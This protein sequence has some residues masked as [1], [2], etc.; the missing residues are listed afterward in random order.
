MAVNI[1]TSSDLHKLGEF[2]L[3]HI[4]SFMDPRTQGLY[5]GTSKYDLKMVVIARQQLFTALFGTTRTCEFLNPHVCEC[6]PF[7]SGKEIACYL[8]LSEKLKM[9]TQNVAIACRRLSKIDSCGSLFSSYETV[10]NPGRF[11]L[12]SGVVRS[13]N[14]FR[15]LEKTGC[16]RNMY[17][18][19]CASDDLSTKMKQ[20]RERLDRVR[21]LLDEYAVFLKSAAEVKGDLRNRAIVLCGYGEKLSLWLKENSEDKSLVTHCFLD[22]FLPKEFEGCEHL[23]AITLSDGEADKETRV[24]CFPRN[25]QSFPRLEKLAI[26]TDINVLPGL[27]E[28]SHATLKELYIYAPLH[29]F[30]E[31]DGKKFPSMEKLHFLACKFGAVPAGISSFT[32]LG[33]LSFEATNT[34]CRL[35]PDIGDIS[36]LRRLNLSGAGISTLPKSLRKL[37]NLV[38]DVSSSLLETALEVEEIEVADISE[39]YWEE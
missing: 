3:P 9:L 7:F 20:R 35:P 33:Y 26:L 11:E 37:P 31:I 2:I 34:L 5:S 19:V 13:V 22:W 23:K 4:A 15:T 24:L 29:D 36:T 1:S 18:P 39:K 17:E 14:L 21:A 27:E 8:E 30:P 16:F 6:V 38:I 25:L 10:S 12:F 32:K 28:A